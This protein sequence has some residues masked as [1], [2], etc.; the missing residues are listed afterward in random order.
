MTERAT[1][2]GFHALHTYWSCPRKYYWSEVRRVEPNTLAPPLA[3]GIATHRALA[4]MLGPTTWWNR[5]LANQAY[6]E[7]LSNA[8]KRYQ[9]VTADWDHIVR[10]VTRILDAYELEY[11][12][13]EDKVGKT[14][15]IEESFEEP[16]G[17]LCHDGLYRAHPPCAACVTKQE[18]SV[19]T[20]RIDRITLL[21][22]FEGAFVE[23]HKT[24]GAGMSVARKLREWRIDKQVT[25]YMFGASRR[26]IHVVGGIFSGIRKLPK[27]IELHRDPQ[28]RDASE[29]RS[30]EVQSCRTISEIKRSAEIFE[31]T[32]DLDIAYPQNTLSCFNGYSQC[33]YYDICL[34][35][36]RETLDA[37]YQDMEKT[38][39]P[40]VREDQPV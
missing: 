22:K 1:V 4:V 13:K 35:P 19:I 25:G 2:W 6:L 40:I 9:N 18:E 11:Q 34:Y 7:F 31:R 10:E 26:G 15:A 21:Q 8:N 14:L 36:G 33:S 32:K 30:L 27:R 12:G 17:H 20:G 29:I 37:Y 24:Y 16:I 38:S 23:D 3:V 28:L 39:L 5:D